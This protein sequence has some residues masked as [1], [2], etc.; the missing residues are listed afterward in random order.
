MAASCICRNQV[1]DFNGEAYRLIEL[2]PNRHWAM[3]SMFDRTTISMSQ[4]ELISRYATGQITLRVGAT[5]ADWLSNRHRAATDP[6][7]SLSAKQGKVRRSAIELPNGD[8][9]TIEQQRRLDLKL[10]MKKAKLAEF[11]YQYPLGSSVQEDAI[12]QKWPAIFGEPAP[13]KLPAAST[14]WRHQK[15]LEAAGGDRRE[16]MPKHHLKGRKTLELHP[17]VTDLIEWAVEEI[18]LTLQRKTMRE[19]QDEL[20]VRIAAENSVGIDIGSLQ[21]V[22]QAN[23]PPQRFNY[24]QRVGRAGRRGQAYSL[25]VTFC[26]GRSHDAYYFAHPSA[27][28]GDPPPPPFLA[29]THDPIPLRLLRKAWLRSAFKLLR[30]QCAAAGNP[31]PGDLLVPPDVHGEYVQTADYYFDSASAWASKLRLALEATIGDRDAYAQAATYDAVQR[32]RLIAAVSVESLLREIEDL[33]PYAPNSQVGLA[34]FLAEWGLLPMYGMPTRVRELYLGLRAERD[35]R[36]SDLEWSTMDRDL[37]LAV[38]EFAP[39]AILTK[40]K[41]KHKVIGF[42]GDLAEP[43]QRRGGPDLRSISRWD[44]SRAYVALCPSCGSAKHQDTVPDVSVTCDDCHGSIPAED[45]KLYVTPTAF[46]TD[47]EPKDDLDEFSRMAVRTVATVAHDGYPLE[48]GPVIVRRG[49]DATIMQLN[50]GSADENGAGRLFNISEAV[51]LKVKV[52]G[53]YRPLPLDGVQAIDQ[54]VL[55]GRGAR[56]DVIPG[57]SQAFGLVA[58]KKTDALYLELKS[59]DSRLSLD[60]VA[61]IGDHS[62]LPTRAAAISATQIIVQKCALELD[63]AAE[64][65]EALEPRL[66]SGRPILQI[67]DTLING[68]GLCR[69]L[70]EPAG[71]VGEPMII[72]LIKKILND[73]DSWPLNDLMMV[74][75]EGAH[76]EQCRTSCYKCIQRYG[77]RRY[78]GLLDWRLGLSY[79]RSMI[80]PTYACGLEVADQKYPEVV[81]WGERAHELAKAVADMRPGTI[82]YKKLGGSSL[83]CLVL[84]D[85]EGREVATAAVIH[86]LWKTDLN[87]AEKLLGSDLTEQM[88]FVDTFNLERRPLREL[89]RI[90]SSS[91]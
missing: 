80:E 31:F 11:A 5:P 8:E 89:A 42:T 76:A 7:L 52:P 41:Q 40:D 33:R 74:D 12:R 66:R 51:D 56:W 45:F 88:T 16:L 70:G 91:H 17:E 37:D 30:E 77:N 1:I 13:V 54:A 58:K 78:H 62:H 71:T 84:R 25:V 35:D 34:K 4:E 44:E 60:R 83:P 27:I 18:Y 75:E 68:S 53:Q 22:Y 14:L 23:M 49:A 38:F 2:M 28:T 24:Q 86:P 26:R 59:F 47:F 82:A 21:S 50:D 55:G 29:V 36:N 57:T 72:E 69:R 87:F 73:S 15:R 3:E 46:R 85:L 20:I 81:G 39:G 10:A 65:F 61:R 19:V 43:Q 90:E 48:C 79:L 64:E 67:A 63:V 32:D 6:P 9:R